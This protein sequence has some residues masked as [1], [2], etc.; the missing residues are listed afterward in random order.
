M[1]QEIQI[2]AASHFLHKK[3]QFVT[4]DT[5]K[6][7][8]LVFHFY[9]G[10]FENIDG[11][12]YHFNANSLAIIL[13]GTPH[14]KFYAEV[15]DVV[16]LHFFAPNSYLKECGVFHIHN[17][18]LHALFARVRDEIDKKNEHH[19]QMLT[20]LLGEI[21]ILLS[22]TKQTPA[23]DNNDIE[24]AARYIDE[25]YRKKIDF[26]KLAAD[27]NYSYDRFRHIFKERMGNA[28][29]DYM[30]ARRLS[31]AKF[32]LETTHQS[33]TNIA[34]LCGF[35]NNAQFSAMFKRHFGEAPATYRKNSK[36]HKETLV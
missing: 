18:E 31:H 25:H 3:G 33:V 2:I 5:H 24:S 8:E 26:R 16:S 29:R 21:L 4:T 28:P 23:P 20:Y 13:P 15:G 12:N 32:L 6:E 36:D 22:R 19:K 9:G 34:E 30:I 17:E 27:C 14:D 35:S 7:Y 1:S 11:K 10:G